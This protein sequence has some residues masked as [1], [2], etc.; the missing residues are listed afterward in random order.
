MTVAGT[1]EGDDR[2]RRIWVELAGSDYETAVRAH[3][4][5]LQVSV[6]GDIVRR[7]TRSYL[8][9][10]SGFQSIPEPTDP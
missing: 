8:T 9:R 7:G 1:T 2:L 3:Q 4:E 6:R 5:M 10:A